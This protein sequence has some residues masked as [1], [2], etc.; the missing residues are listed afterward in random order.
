M[1]WHH[2]ASQGTVGHGMIRHGMVRH[3]MVRHGMVRHSMARHDM[4]RRG[5]AWE[6]M[7]RPFTCCRETLPRLSYYMQRLLVRQ[8]SKIRS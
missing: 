3:G 2:M 7:L 8:G 4:V 5:M 1:A 6:G